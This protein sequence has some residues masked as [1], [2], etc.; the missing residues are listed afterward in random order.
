VELLANGRLAQKAVELLLKETT[1]ATT[2]DAE[3]PESDND[4]V[5]LSSTASESSSLPVVVYGL[6]KFLAAVEASPTLTR[7]FV[8]TRSGHGTLH[9]WGGP[10]LDPEHPR[11]LMALLGVLMYSF[12]SAGQGAAPEAQGSCPAKQ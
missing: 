2:Q 12:V 4:V 9:V 10:F 11:I 6:D 7:T 5:V 1:R 8:C 3:D